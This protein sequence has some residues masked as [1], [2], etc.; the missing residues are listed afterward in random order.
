MKPYS[1]YYET[2]TRRVEYRTILPDGER[3][4]PEQNA[5]MESYGCYGFHINR[6]IAGN[7]TIIDELRFSIDRDILEDGMKQD[8]KDLIEQATQN[9]FYGT[10]EHHQTVIPDTIRNA[11]LIETIH[12]S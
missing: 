12:W 4:T 7:G 1:I 2:D 8:D 3:L 6:W 10:T 11:Q 5:D 9:T